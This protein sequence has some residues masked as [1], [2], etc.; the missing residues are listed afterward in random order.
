MARGS[1][2]APISRHGDPRPL[3]KQRSDEDRAAMRDEVAWVGAWADR[4]SKAILEG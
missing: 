3:V 1:P 4:L 2:A